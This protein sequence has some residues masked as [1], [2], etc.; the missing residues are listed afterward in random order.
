[1]QLFTTAQVLEGTAGYSALINVLAVT[2]AGLDNVPE[3]TR[4]GL[5]S[6]SFLIAVS[7]QCERLI[8]SKGLQSDEMEIVEQA[9][10]TFE[11]LV[12]R[13]KGGE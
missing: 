12:R 5:D 1:M 8:Q 2:I 9:L 3:S 13:Y 10:E 7:A 6:R 4:Q 11:G